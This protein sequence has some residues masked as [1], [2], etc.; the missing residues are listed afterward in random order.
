MGGKRWWCFTNFKLDFD[1]D[2]MMKREDAPQWIGWGLETC[3]STGKLHHQGYM[4]FAT[5]RESYK[6]TAKIL[7]KC[8]VDQCKGTPEHNDVYCRKDGDFHE[9]GV[10]PTQ[11]KRTDLTE[12]KQRVV[13]GESVDAIVLEDPMAYHQYGRT[14][15][16]IEDIALRKRKRTWMTQ[17]EWIWGP[18]GTGKSK[19]AFEGFDEKT[20]YVVPNDNGWW[21]GYTGQETVI[22]DDFRG[23][24]TYHEL[25]TLVD[26][27]PK[28]VK[29]RNREPA[30]FLAQRL[31]I[32]SSLPP[33]EVYRNLSVRDGLEQLMRRFQI[34]GSEVVGGNI[35]P[36]L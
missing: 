33:E 5:Q 8:W 13:D 16:R 10:R 30:P 32:T 20:H 36:D 6:N 22:M 24:M 7:G 15:N 2:E 26:R 35:D 27:Y 23:D 21:D 9:W 12:L 25:L 4:W 11:G 19:R 34:F 1:Y 14:L 18:T 29:R 17:G 3:P 28:T 31:I